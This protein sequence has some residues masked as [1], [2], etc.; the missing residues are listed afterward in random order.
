MKTL[1]PQLLNMHSYLKCLAVCRQWHGTRH[2]WYIIQM[3]HSRTKHLGLIMPRVDWSSN[4]NSCM[5]ALLSRPST[6]ILCDCYVFVLKMQLFLLHKCPVSPNLLKWDFFRCGWLLLKQYVND[7]SFI[8]FLLY[9]LPCDPL[10][11]LLNV[12]TVVPCWSSYSGWAVSY[13]CCT[14]L[15]FLFRLGYVIPLLIVLSGNH[16]WFYFWDANWLLSRL[17]CLLN[18]GLNEIVFWIER[19]DFLVGF[20]DLIDLISINL[21]SYFNSMWTKH[22]AWVL[23]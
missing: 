7:N 16:T 10:L 23:I 20:L 6:L 22:V 19:C 4:E 12:G 14:L 13:P 18:V 17:V 21:Q 15:V 3:S 9:L 8:M 2:S 11:L 5:Y 1:G